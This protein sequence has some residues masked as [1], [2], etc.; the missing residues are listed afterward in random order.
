MNF[1]AKFFNV[2][3]GDSI[4]IELFPEDSEPKVVL[5]DCAK[6]KGFRGT[7][8]PVYEYLLE[9]EIVEIDAIFITHF[10]TDHFEGIHN[11]LENKDINVK[12]IYIPPVFSLESGQSDKRINQARLRIK[13]YSN[14]MSKSDHHNKLRLTSLAKLIRYIRENPDMIFEMN[15]PKNE[16]SLALDS[17][18]KFSVFLPLNEVKGAINSKL[19][20]ESIDILHFSEMNDASL[21]IVL[22]TEEKKFFFTGDSTLDQWQK[23]KKML[24]RQNISNL[25]ADFLKVSHH[26]SKDNYEDE[27][28]DYILKNEENIYALISANG[29]SH[30]HLNVLKSLNSRSCLIRCTNLLDKCA[31][32]LAGMI[33]LSNTSME[34]AVMISKY[35]ISTD[36]VMCQGD[37][38]IEFQNGQIGYSSETQMPCVYG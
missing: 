21:V 14:K 4:L 7:G 17:S 2:N 11:I 37:M 9:R 18:T 5:I 35:E 1:R 23:H 31:P 25:G 24:G 26:G 32:N 19:G 34:I 6:K 8:C 12:A 16:V 28:I 20:D 30:P 15:G 38:M 13:E 29:K 27:I 33:D 10:H 22:E 3:H 36:P